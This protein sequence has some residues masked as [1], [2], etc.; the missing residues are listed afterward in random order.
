[1]KLLEIYSKWVLNLSCMITRGTL[2]SIFK[3]IDILSTDL[4]IRP[5]IYFTDRLFYS[6]I[7]HLVDLFIRLK[8]NFYQ[9]HELTNQ[10]FYRR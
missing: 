8:W 10:H 9:R 5:R 7:Q 1:M 6:E 3:W 4:T 2:K